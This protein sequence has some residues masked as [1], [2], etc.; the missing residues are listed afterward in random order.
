M[1]TC[2]FADEFNTD[3][4]N[5]LNDN[6]YLNCVICD[7]FTVPNWFDFWNDN[8]FVIYIAILDLILPFQNHND[9]ENVPVNFW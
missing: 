5:K 6:K 4:I 2:D 9:I 8:P 7:A 1:D 3:L